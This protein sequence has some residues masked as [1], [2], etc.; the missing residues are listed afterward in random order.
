MQKFLKEYVPY[1]VIIIVVILVRSYIVTPVRVNGTS[2]DN[3]LVHGEIMILYK[4]G[5]IKR[6]SIVVIDKAVEGNNII[7]RIVGLPGETIKC[8]D[9]IIYIDERIYED[10]YANGKTSDFSEIKLASDEYFVLGDNRKVSEDSR[11]LG[12]IKAKF[13]KGTTNFALYPFKRFG[14]VE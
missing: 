2:M 13:I 1:I 3:T 9:G 14:K 8:E 10:K 11:M 7:K 6:N 4:R 12:P 5:T